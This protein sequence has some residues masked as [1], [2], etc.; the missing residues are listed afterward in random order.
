MRAVYGAEIDSE[1]NVF[2]DKQKLDH[3]ATVEEVGCIADRE[4]VRRRQKRHIFT[5]PIVLARTEV[6]DRA[7]FSLGDVGEPADMNGPIVNELICGE[8]VECL[9]HRVPPDNTNI[10]GGVGELSIGLANEFAEIEQVSCLYIIF[11]RLARLCDRRGDSKTKK[12]ERDGERTMAAKA[13][14]AFQ[15]QSLR[16]KAPLHMPAIEQYLMAPNEPSV[17]T[18]FDQHVWRWINSEFQV[19]RLK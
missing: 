3:A 16:W 18:S 19:V 13:V 1:A 17:D 12:K 10:K 11:R 9:A 14:E 4:C 8:I 15:S 5:E 2:V 7:T 6:D